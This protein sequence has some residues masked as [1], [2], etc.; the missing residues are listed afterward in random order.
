[1][2]TEE[3]NTMILT[4]NKV[5]LPEEVK[6]YLEAHPQA[7]EIYTLCRETYLTNFNSSMY[8]TEE[9]IAINILPEDIQEL[10]KIIKAHCKILFPYSKDTK[11]NFIAILPVIEKY[12]SK[13]STPEEREKRRAFIPSEGNSLSIGTYYPTN[14]I[15]K[16]NDFAKML[17][18][19]A[20]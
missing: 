18:D 4:E 5:N 17:I 10:A 19:E 20:F 7:S 2:K 1:M 16:W 6:T 9:G 13:T 15:P 14:K 8:Q 11:D 12:Y 3:F